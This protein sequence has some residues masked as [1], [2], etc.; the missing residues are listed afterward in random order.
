MR[1]CV[2]GHGP[3]QLGAVPQGPSGPR[4]PHPAGKRQRRARPPPGHRERI[5]PDTARLGS[6]ATLS[7]RQADGG[8]RPLAA[9]PAPTLPRPIPRR[10][11]S[12]PSPPRPRARSKRRLRHCLARPPPAPATHVPDSEEDEGGGKQQRQHVA[13]GRES[14]RHGRGGEGSSAGAS[15]ETR[16]R[17]LWVKPFTSP[18][19]SQD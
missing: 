9:R 8:R 1:G 19:H 5:H 11:P 4:L 3:H 12:W 15:G 10:G 16:R 13:E 6:S 14:E 2:P 18:S 7:P 17:A